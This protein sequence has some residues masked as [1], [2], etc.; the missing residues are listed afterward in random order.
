MQ[1]TCVAGDADR[2]QSGAAMSM[3]TYARNC[4]LHPTLIAVISILSIGLA[5]AIGLGANKLSASMGVPISGISAVSLFGLLWLLFDQHLWKFGFLRRALLVPDLNGTWRCAGKTVTQ[6]GD[7]AD[8]EWESE[9]TIRQSWSKIFIRLKTAQSGSKSI[10][11]SLYHEGD[12]CYRLMY[13][14]ENDP[15]PSEQELKHHRGFADLLFDASVGSA[16]GRYFTDGDRL[17]V[18]EMELTRIRSKK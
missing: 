6:G 8:F 2:R 9:I 12:G 7:S 13:P 11:A 17:T 16:E 5:W 14:Y 1:N 10:T 4:K 18:G 15:K 3:H